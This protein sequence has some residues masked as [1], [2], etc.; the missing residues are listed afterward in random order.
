MGLEGSGGITTSTPLGPTS[1]DDPPDH[2]I[3]P[4]YQVSLYAE[5][6][7]ARAHHDGRISLLSD[8]NVSIV[9]V[10]GGSGDPV[11]FEL[12]VAVK[13]FS[14]AITDRLQLQLEAEAHGS[15]DSD[16]G[17]SAGGELGFGFEGEIDEHSSVSVSGTFGLTFP[18]HGPPEA[19]VGVQL[20][21]TVHP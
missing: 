6:A 18:D 12:A 20:G 5:W 7:G 14:A 11:E 10:A 1:P 21:F 8:P 15:V 3:H 9:G 4:T 17:A 2:A 16:G 19:E 13:V